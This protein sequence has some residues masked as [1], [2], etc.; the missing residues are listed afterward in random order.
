MAE[1]KD[2]DDA[3]ERD[4][5]A[6]KLDKLAEQAIADDKA[7]RTMPLVAEAKHTPL[8]WRLNPA[9]HP[10]IGD[11]GNPSVFKTVASTWNDE[12]L[13]DARFIVRA[14]N[15]HEALVQASTAFLAAY[16]EQDSAIPDSD[17]DDEQ[18]KSITV[19]LGDLRALR[20][21]LASADAW[22][23]ARADGGAAKAT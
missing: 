14:V 9:S 15:A 18:T 16:E 13:A 23:L 12:G 22:P 8:P 5:K 19:T 20:R 1:E 7:G 2:F 10:T 6:G 17:L 3:I 11:I 4:A 21:A